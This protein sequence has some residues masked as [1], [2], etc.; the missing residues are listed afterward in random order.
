M[1]I[2]VPEQMREW[3]LK[4]IQGGRYASTSDYVRDLIRQDQDKNDRIIHLKEALE[5]GLNSGVS[6]KTNEDVLREA[7]QVNKRSWAETFGY[8]YSNSTSSSIKSSC[9]KSW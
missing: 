6:D 1:N 5:E 7:R 4:Q 9:S 8:T 3:V 2:S